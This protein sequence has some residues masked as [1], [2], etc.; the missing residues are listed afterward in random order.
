MEAPEELNELHK[1]VGRM[2]SMLK[3][4]DR[5]QSIDVTRHQQ[6]AEDRILEA[7]E[8]VRA[9]DTQVAQAEA[10]AE[11]LRQEVDAQQRLL[12]RLQNTRE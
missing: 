11:Q 6:A 3:R 8:R 2:M 9:A 5:M 1:N 4:A 12:A 7:E 10:E